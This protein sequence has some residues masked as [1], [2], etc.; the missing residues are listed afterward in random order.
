MPRFGL[1]VF[2]SD[3]KSRMRP[4]GSKQAQDDAQW[5]LSLGAGEFASALQDA[6]PLG[7]RG[8]EK[9]GNFEAA[10]AWIHHLGSP[11]SAL[12]HS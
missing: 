1:K 4:R 3:K 9:G 7:P 11:S 6:S 10:S 2:R 8:L 5:R 12:V